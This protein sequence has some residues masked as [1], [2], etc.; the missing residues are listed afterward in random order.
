M[1]TFHVNLHPNIAAV[2]IID[3]GGAVHEF[4]EGAA[5]N[6]RFDFA[7]VTKLL[8]THVIADGISAGF[9]QL[10]DPIYDPYFTKG[11]V[12]LI[13]LLSH[14][15]GTRLDGQECVAPRTKR[16]YT[17]EAFEIAE[18]FFI[19]SLGT[20]FEKST[21]GTLFEEGL[22]P[23][24]NSSISFKGSCASS[25]KGTFND[26]MLILHEIRSPQFLDHDM[27]AKL[28]NP[29]HP[30]LAGII[31][32][33]GHME[34]NLWGTGYQLRGENSHWMG[35]HS[36]PTTYGHFGQSAAFVMHDP[37]NN[38][39]IATVSNQ[40]FGPWAKDAWPLLV[41]ELFEKYC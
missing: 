14:A 15:S 19:N 27:H 4:G 25:A 28:I 34:N 23:Q 11:F 37:V 8:T 21:I 41:D 36:S 9:A 13:D 38:I 33:F 7:S 40:D 30:E 39:S 17:N 22:G 6:R 16:I 32:G 10:D 24:L 5:N 12:T 1:Y 18:K 29:Y 3:P 26:V 31:P 20:G 2:G 35:S